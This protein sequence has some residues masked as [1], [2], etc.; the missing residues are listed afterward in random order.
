MMPESKAPQM[1]ADPVFLSKGFLSW[2]VLYTRSHCEQQVYTALSRK[3]FDLFLPQAESWRQRRG[4]CHKIRMPIFPGYL[5][6]RGTID[7]V[8]YL[9]VLRTPGAVRLLGETWNRLAVV[10]EEEILAIQRMVMSEEPL[11]PFPNPKVGERLRVK[12][13]PLEGIEGLLVEIDRRRSLF[14][15]TF[16][17]LQRSVAIRIDPGRLERC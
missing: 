6:L 1:G 5:F 17:L 11:C 15:V 9:E 2:H 12:D 4:K 14:V 7:K 8:S 16:E 10:P 3:A 13:G